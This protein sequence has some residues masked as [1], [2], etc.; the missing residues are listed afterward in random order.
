MFGKGVYFVAMHMDLSHDTI[1]VYSQCLQVMSPDSSITGKNMKSP[2]CFDSPFCAFVQLL[3]HY[4]LP[5]SLR[6]F[7]EIK[8]STRRHVCLRLCMDGCLFVA[9]IC[10]NNSFAFVSLVNGSIFTVQLTNDSGL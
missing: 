2:V 8:L 1:H 7:Q 4:Q 5:R 6:P 9:G 3:A 10:C